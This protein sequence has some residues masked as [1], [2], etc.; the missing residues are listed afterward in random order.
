MT[1]HEQYSF[2][3]CDIQTQRT[4]GAAAGANKGCRF[5]GEEADVGDVLQAAQNLT[6][7]V[8]DS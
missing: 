6:C 1:R 3:P 5:A 7:L 4:T 8:S 2:L